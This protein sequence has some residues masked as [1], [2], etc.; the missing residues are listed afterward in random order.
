MA[1]LIMR[2]CCIL[3]E[4]LKRD[5]EVLYRTHNFSVTPAY[6]QIG[7]E[8]YLLVCTNEHYIG[9]GGTPSALEC[10]LETVISKTLNVIADSYSPEIVVFEHGPK[11]DCH[12]GG[13]CLDHTHLH[14]VPT[15]VDVFGFLF[16]KHFKPEK[17]QGLERLRKIYETNN[18]SYLLLETQERKRFVFE[19][20]IIP[21]QYLR[22]I[23][24]M[25]EGRSNWDWRKYPD[26]ETF[27]KTLEKLRGKF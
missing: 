19:V 14:V 17:I 27:K 1:I 9:I 12:K 4:Q 22:Q 11:S 13:G 23:I 20:D 15:K 7:I 2:S 8:G 26:E 5:R 24:A 10:E 6:G 3:G 18:S 25:G 16:N 21:S